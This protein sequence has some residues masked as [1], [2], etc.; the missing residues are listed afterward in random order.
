MNLE[1]R[2]IVKKTIQFQ[3]WF[4]K[5][6]DEHAKHLI[7]AKIRRIEIDGYFGDC[8]PIG[9]KLFELRI[10]HGPGYRIYFRQ[11]GM[12][13]VIVLLGGVKK[14]QRRDIVMAKNIVWN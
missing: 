12:N 11:Q 3:K 8:K 2:V 5:L 6:K 13:L 14:S 7:M 4:D 9:D 1:V 10:N